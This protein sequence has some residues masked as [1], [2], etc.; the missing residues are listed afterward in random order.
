MV[1]GIGFV[2]SSYAIKKYLDTRII[3]AAFPALNKNSCQTLS[4][5]KFDPDP[6]M[7]NARLPSHPLPGAV[8][9]RCAQEVVNAVQPGEAK[10]APKNI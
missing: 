5:G 2:F 4:E 6:E 9:R 7:Y 8:A 1:F 10:E 3:F